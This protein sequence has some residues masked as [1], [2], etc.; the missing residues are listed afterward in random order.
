MFHR[1]PR[2]SRPEIRIVSRIRDSRSR[3]HVL[4]RESSGIDSMRPPFDGPLCYQYRFHVALADFVDH[5]VL[6]PSVNHY[7]IQK[8]IH[9]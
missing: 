2:R 3:A 6:I 7:L 5:S 4:S 9:L 1:V 8:F